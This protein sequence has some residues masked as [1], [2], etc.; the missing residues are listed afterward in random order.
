MTYVMSG[1]LLIVYFLQ[2]ILLCGILRSI[3]SSENYYR[4]FPTICINTQ[5]MNFIT[6]FHLKSKKNWRNIIFKKSKNA[7][8]FFQISNQTPGNS[9]ETHPGNPSVIFSRRMNLFKIL[10]NI[11]LKKQS[12]KS[13]ASIFISKTCF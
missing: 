11:S 4:N 9:A 5:L 8:I 12:A 10:F 7:S 3:Y 13:S 1:L 2:D 6:I